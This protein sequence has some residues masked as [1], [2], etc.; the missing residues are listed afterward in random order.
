[1]ETSCAA[2][3]AVP[4]AAVLAC[5]QGCHT[6]GCPWCITALRTNWED[7]ELR[8]RLRHFSCTTAA[9]LG[10]STCIFALAAISAR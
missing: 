4:L 9:A 10:C 8:R 2:S 1:M 7:R 3:I 5:C 6:A